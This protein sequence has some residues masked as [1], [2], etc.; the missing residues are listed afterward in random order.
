MKKHLRL[1]SALLT[2]VMVVSLVVPAGTANQVEAGTARI[3]FKNVSGEGENKISLTDE[4]SFKATVKLPKG[5]SKKEAETRKK[6]AK[7][8]LSRKEGSHNPEDYPY[9]YLGGSLK[10][11]KTFFDNKAFFYNM[12]SSVSKKNGRYYLTLKFKN[13]YLYD[14]IDGIDGRKRSI[15]RSSMLDY[16]GDFTF[17][18]KDKKGNKLGATS[19]RVNPYDDY[20]MNSEFGTELIEACD[21]AATRDDIYAEVR[22]MGTTSNGYDMPYILIADKKESLTNWEALSVKM[23]ENPESVI[24]DVKNDKIDYRI[25]VLYSN[26]HADE[27]PGADAPMNFIWDLVKSNENNGKIKFQYIKGFTKNGEKQLKA[28]MAAG[29]NH[30]SELITALDNGPTGVGFITDGKANSKTINMKKFYDI[31]TIELDVNELL[32]KVFFIV[33]PEE[34]GDARTVNTRNNGNGFDLN[35]DNLFQTQAETRA[36]TSMIAHWN[37]SLFI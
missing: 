20:R 33:V 28:E 31:E 36:M 17:T 14:G 13:R 23:Q 37:P 30:W 16:T 8:S 10:S 21:Y 26:V 25:P 2:L 27:N 19:V 12:K 24:E 22:S 6:S 15:V 9:Q 5:T 32:S 3:S 1:W 29:G 7:W 11:W 18:V 4:R 35:R 34:N